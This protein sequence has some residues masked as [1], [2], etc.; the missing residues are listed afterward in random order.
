VRLSVPLAILLGAL[1]A[2]GPEVASAQP[3]RPPPK[4]VPTR[5]HAPPRRPPTRPPRTKPV[6]KPSATRSLESRLGFGVATRLLASKERDDRI[7]GLERLG[8]VGTPAALELLA[9]SLEPGG[10]AKTL[11]ERLTAVRALARHTRS[12]VARPALARVMASASSNDDAGESLLRG[13]AALALA[14][15]GDSAAIELLGKALRQEGPIAQAAATA[16]VGHPPRN[17]GPITRTRGALTLALIDALEKLGDQRAFNALR[18]VVKY[19]PPEYQARA[20]L[21]LTRLGDF[22]TVALARVWLAK[23]KEPSLRSAAAE[24]LALAGT[25]DAPKRIAALLVA[26]DT[27]SAGLSLALESPSPTLVPTLSAL[28]AKADAGNVPSLLGAIG[29]AGGERAAEV[30]GREL[31]HPERAASAAYAL[32]LSPGPDARRVLSS[33]LA[34]P[35]V[36]RYAAR[37]AVVRQLV[38]GESVDG[39]D[40]T[41]PLL[42]AAADPGERA[43]GAWC[44]AALDEDRAV[45]L[46]RRSDPVVV[47]AAARAALTPKAARAAAD[48]LTDALDPETKT[49]LAIGLANDAAANRVPTHVLRELVESGGAAAPLAARALALRDDATLRPELTILLDS[50]DP[51]IRAHVALGLGKS[52]S[53]SALGLL[54]RR[55]AFE[56]DE[57]V[58]HA[59][60][61]ALGSRREPTRERPLRLAADLDPDGRVRQA[62]RRALSGTPLSALPGGHGTFWLELVDSTSEKGRDHAALLATSGG[63]V[64]PVVSDPDG[65]LSVA[66]L[67]AG[68]VSLRLAASGSEGKASTP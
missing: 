21:A 12:V 63:M 16:L 44:F 25:S 17:L 9:K 26:P 59:I 6:A 68:P 45:T 23:R 2:A 20:A 66:R 57:L 3:R 14:R 27:A 42:L 61:T 62:A 53:P 47:R 33:K 19:G 29:R 64:L 46:I 54:E 43:A 56:R 58:R 41:L 24:I 5:P 37:A 50:G 49:A 65:L 22:E 51:W 67:P 1:F 48:R 4:I 13:T 40:D 11:E 30:L 55:Y 32:A 36:R 34:D 39:L 15:S 52:K 28:L 35:R 60:V 38:L 7:R 8:S 10:A 31:G 18:G